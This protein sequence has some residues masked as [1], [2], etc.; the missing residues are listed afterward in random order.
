MLDAKL[1]V[2]TSI[3]LALLDLEGHQ[4]ALLLRIVFRQRLPH[5]HIGKAVLQVKRRI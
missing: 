1:T 2:A 3:L 4:E 5:L